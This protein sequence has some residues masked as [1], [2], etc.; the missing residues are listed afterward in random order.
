MRSRWFGAAC[1]AVSLAAGACTSSPTSRAGPGTSGTTN[2]G[3]SAGTV[4]WAPGAAEAA[5][6]APP[7]STAAG[8]CGSDSAT[9]LAELAT[10]SPDQARVAREWADVVPGGKQIL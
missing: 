9:Y 2:A 8:T 4:R 1:V 5:D 10:T 3:G 6:G 7:A